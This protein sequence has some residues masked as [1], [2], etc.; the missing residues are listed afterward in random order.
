MPLSDTAIRNAKPGIKP[1][2]KPC[3]GA[4]KMGDKDGLYLTV[5]K[6]GG[7]LWRYDYRFHGKRKTL[8][9][10]KYPALSLKAARA[11]LSD[12]RAQLA[13]GIDPA[14][15]K[16]AT[17]TAKREAGA[18]TFQAV[19]LEWF[20]KQ[21]PHWAPANARVVLGRLENNLFPWIGAEPVAD[22]TAPKLLATLRRIE[23][24]GAHE[25]A[26][27]C[28]ALAGQIMRYAIACGLAERDP[29]ADLRG[30]LTPVKPR[31]MPAITEPKLLGEL[32]RAIEGY[33]GSFPVRVALQLA[34]MLAV[35]PGELRGARWEEIDLEAGEWNIPAERMKGGRP[36]WVPLPRQAVELLRELYPLTGPEGFLFPSE[37]TKARCM[38]DNTVNAAL[39]RL[40]FDRDTV[41]GHGFRATFS[42]MLNGMGYDPDVIERQLAHK[43]RDAI[44]AAYHRTEYRE[45][46][47]AMLQA[48]ADY[49]DGLKTGAEV[50]PFK[51]TGGAA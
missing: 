43:E 48:W 18:N 31:P 25:T 28:R 33:Q 46:R 34:P 14:E 9:L 2:G 7:K 15:H 12:A 45:D 38:S 3:G 29:A 36:H 17:K 41:V 27:R 5:T 23:N 37:R 21:S 19:A 51:K 11:K 40:G 10:G 6:A 39:R 13:E 49:L 50:V 30:A 8:S 20:A 24:R 26:H 32:L 4:Y 44:R 22:I 47:R 1:D 42:T 35:R 16:Q